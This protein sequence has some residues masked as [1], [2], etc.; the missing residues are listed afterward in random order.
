MTLITPT[1]LSVMI[2][3]LVRETNFRL[4]R[5]K[6]QC[7]SGDW[8]HWAG[9]TNLAVVKITDSMCLLKLKLLYIYIYIYI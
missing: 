4:Q 3:N 2:Q 7:T 9:S 6:L 5:G 8:S 1:L